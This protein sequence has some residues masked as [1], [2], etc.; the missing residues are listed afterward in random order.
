M[1]SSFILHDCGPR[2]RGQIGGFLMETPPTSVSRAVAPI[3]SLSPKR[4][5]MIDDLPDALF[6][7]VADACADDPVLASR[8][9][10][11]RAGRGAHATAGTGHPTRR[12]PPRTCTVCQVTYITAVALP[13][14]VSPEEWVCGVCL[15]DPRVDPPVRGGTLDV[16]GSREP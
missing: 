12:F 5:V 10:R 15:Q 1:L 14:S 6:N 7:E 2:L 4:A 11:R 3:T 16:D 13:P 9:A 8:P